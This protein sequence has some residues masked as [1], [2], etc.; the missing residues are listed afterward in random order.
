VDEFT[1]VVGLFSIVGTVGTMIQ[2]YVLFKKDTPPQ[3]GRSPVAVQSD[4]KKD[5][6]IHTSGR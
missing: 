3:E 5:E 4:G 6:A 1:V 2:V